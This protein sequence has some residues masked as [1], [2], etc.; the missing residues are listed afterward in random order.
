MMKFGVSTDTSGATEVYLIA[1]ELD[2]VF[3][4]LESKFRTT[5]LEIFFV[6][7]C[8]PDALGRKSSRRLSK[9]E[10]VFYLD[11]SFSED[12]LSG[13]D[14]EQQRSV[15]AGYFFEYLEDSLKKYKFKDLDIPSFM[16]AFRDAA[17]SIGWVA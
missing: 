11:M 8:L 17:V 15:V 12:S 1:N 4:V 3:S 10:S 16:A 14:L 7:R 6:F 5:D 2:A 13:M 9:S